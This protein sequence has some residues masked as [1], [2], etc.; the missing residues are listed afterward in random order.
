MD[1]KT[2]TDYV[3]SLKAKTKCQRAIVVIDYLQVWPTNASMRFLNEN[4]IDK[5]RIGEMKKL[6]DFLS[7]DPVIVISEARKPNL[8]ENTWG[9]DLSDVMGSARTTYTPD[10]VMLLTPIKGKQLQML[11][12]EHRMPSIGYLGQEDE[13]SKI[14]SFLEEQGIALCK[15]EVPKARDGMQKFSL[16]L[17]F[18]F[19]RNKFKKLDLERL[20]KTLNVSTS[21]Q[22]KPSKKKGNSRSFADL[23]LEV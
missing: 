13:G 6:K 14:K 19:Q 23:F 16:F 18:H 7:M 11:W 8:K 12:E 17:E 3:S 5:W 22:A 20:R 9:G 4:E 10:V 2:I 1:A 21:G 15:L